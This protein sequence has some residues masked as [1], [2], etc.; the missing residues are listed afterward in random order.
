ING[1]TSLVNYYV[2]GEYLNAGGPF[3]GH[4]HETYTTNSWYKRYNLRNNLDFNVTK[5][6]ILRVSLS[7]TIETKNDANHDDSSGQR[8][9]GSFWRNILNLTP[10]EYPVFNP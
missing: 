7:G 3:N 9:A 1:G 6:T 5:S 4:D 2:S 8:Y 10:H